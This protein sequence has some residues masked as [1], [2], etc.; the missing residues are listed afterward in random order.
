MKRLG[1]VMT[2][3]SLTATLLSGCDESN[4]KTPLLFG[5]TNNELYALSYEQYVAKIDKKD[6]FLVFSTP[7]SPCTCWTSFRDSILMPYRKTNNLII[8]TVHYSEFFD[9]DNARRESY[10]LDFLSSSQT[11]GLF[12]NGVIKENRPYNSTHKI[13]SSKDSFTTYMSELIIN[14]TIIDVSL[15]KLNA[16]YEQNLSFSIMFYDEKGES[17][18]LRDNLLTTYA[19]ENYATMN[20]LYTL[21]TFVEGIQL[22]SGIF[23]EA[24]WQTFKDTY[25]LSAV[26]NASFGYDGGFVP[27]IQYIEPNGSSTNQTVI[28]AQAVYLNDAISV[29]ANPGSYEVSDSFYS[30]AR[31]N[32]LLYLADY[33][34]VRVLIGTEIPAAD[35]LVESETATWKFEKAASYHDPLFQAFLDYSLPLTTFVLE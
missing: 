1:I 10:G 5:T 20:N 13:W 6:S 14:P 3:I 24:Q 23:D 31:E 25:G 17:S 9:D 28:K 33:S 18:Y 2:A 26:N 8:Y 22:S 19:R 12:K 11:L 27:T 34:G 35:V 32:L 7:N 4:S 29:A 30:S 16:L 15:T 21:N